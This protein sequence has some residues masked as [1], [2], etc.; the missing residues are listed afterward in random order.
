MNRPTALPCALTFTLVLA[1]ALGA[2]AVL[3]P[4]ETA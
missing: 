3:R 2:A 1:I 4:G